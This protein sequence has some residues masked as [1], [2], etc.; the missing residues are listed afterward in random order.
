PYLA[1]IR[2]PA[3]LL[4]RRARPLG[5]DIELDDARALLLAVVPHA[6]FAGLHLVRPRAGA[7]LRERRRLLP[8][9]VECVTRAALLVGPDVRDLVREQDGVVVV[10]ARRIRGSRR[11]RLEIPSGISRVD[12][13]GVARDHRGGARGLERAR[14]VK[15]HRTRIE[16][17]SEQA[18]DAAALVIG[19]APA[20]HGVAVGEDVVDVHALRLAGRDELLEAHRVDD[21]TEAPV[22]NAERERAHERRPVGGVDQ[23][24]YGLT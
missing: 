23:A 7:G 9:S 12:L 5:L 3:L 8:D 1:H 20:R 10:S 24:G 19:E 18:L 13:H 14:E 15:A 22:V 4:A 16:R 11:A 6:R 2:R 17:V 21:A